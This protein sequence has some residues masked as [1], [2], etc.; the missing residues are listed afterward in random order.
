[1]N[2]ETYYNNNYIKLFLIL[3]FFSCWISI[4]T[5]TLDVYKVFYIY[6]LNYFI[7]GADAEKI[8]PSLN[9]II[10]CFRQL[11]MF[12]IFPI[13]LIINF[14]KFNFTNIKY[15]FPLFCFFIYFLTQFIGLILTENTYLNVGFIISALNILLILNITNRLANNNISKIFIILTFCFLILINI[16]NKD[17][18]INFFLSTK[19]STLYTSFFASSDYFFGKASPRSTG[20]SRS[21]LL[22]FIISLILFKNFFNKNKKT[23]YIFYILVSTLILLF[24][25]RTVIVLLIVFLIFYFFIEKNKNFFKYLIAYFVIPII[26]LYSSIYLKN[27]EWIK[28]QIA[29]GAMD[30]QY[31]SEIEASIFMI[32]KNI[33]RPIDPSTFSSGRMNDWKN[34]IKKSKDSLYF[35]FGSQ[36]DRYL[37]NQTASNGLIY[38]FTSSGILGVIFYLIFVFAILFK[39]F[40]VLILKFR[41]SSYEDKYCA[42]ILLLIL[43]RSILETSFSVFGVDFII[44]CTFYNYISKKNLNKNHG[45]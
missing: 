8:F 41:L 45:F 3:S 13:L 26:F 14:F 37:I 21:L 15:D 31:M 23:K 7:L 6:K 40:E 33:K 10:N 30:H 18:Y 42:I 24:Q 44:L 39:I 32:E 28:Y 38:A 16:L 20:T 19:A 9:E 1:M 27:N 36:S 2:K 43:L 12:I 35:G 17:V 4:S 5:T 22:L 25:S 34:L 29:L 11:I